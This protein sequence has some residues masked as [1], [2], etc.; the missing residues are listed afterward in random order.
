[1]RARQRWYRWSA[2]AAMGFAV[3][4]AVLAALS[5]A[6]GL[7]YAAA[8]A[9]AVATAVLHNAAWHDAWTWAD[10]PAGLRT[11]LLRIAQLAGVTALVSVAGGVAL[12]VLWVQLVGL[13]VM[14]ANVL[15]VASLGVVNFVAADRGVFASTGP[16]GTSLGN[17]RPGPGCGYAGARGGPIPVRRV[18]NVSISNATRPIG[19]VCTG[20]RKW[21]G[22]RTAAPRN[23]KRSGGQDLG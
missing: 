22:S 18:R 14:A 17:P 8:M 2:V 16:P 4:T 23:A 5:A 19:S 6:V 7:H 20:V 10:R 13:P 3:Q 1:M 12:T 11:R 9:I 15:T 21:S